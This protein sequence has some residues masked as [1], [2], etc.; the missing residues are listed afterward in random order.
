MNITASFQSFTVSALHVSVA[1]RS[2]GAASSTATAASAAAGTDTVSLSTAAAPAPPT[3]TNDAVTTGTTPHTSEP[4]SP[5]F[6]VL[7]ADQ[8]GAVTKAEF[9]SGALALLGR[10]GDH[11]RVHGNADGENGRRARGV[12]GLERRLEKAFD[13]VDANDDGSLDQGEMTAA[14]SREDEATTDVPSPRESQATS[15][16]GV[17]ASFVSVTYVSVAIQRYTSIQTLAPSSP[18]SSATVP[19]SDNGV[20]VNTPSAA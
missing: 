2:A 10:R 20:G 18:G 5:L 4:P 15:Q 14:L 19:S 13:R 8:D 6:A 12:P 7:D 3:S 9:T 16:A 17:S 11:P 1:G